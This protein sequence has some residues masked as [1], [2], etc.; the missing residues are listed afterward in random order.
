[1]YNVFGMAKFKVGDHIIVN[2]DTRWYWGEVIMVSD[3]EYFVSWGY[4]FNKTLSHPHRWVEEHYKLDINKMR[5]VIL[6]E[7]L[8]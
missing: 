2:N 5:N 8:S 6:G 1:M 4:D 3:Y 7:I